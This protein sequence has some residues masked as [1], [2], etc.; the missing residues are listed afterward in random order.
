MKGRMLCLC[1]VTA[2]FALG[3]NAQTISYRLAADVPFAFMAGPTQLPAG[4]YYIDTLSPAVVRLATTDRSAAAMLIVNGATRVSSER[5]GKLVFH[6][7]GDRYFL[8]NVWAPGAS[9]GIVVR[10]SALERE[11][12]AGVKDPETRVVMVRRQ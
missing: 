9:D 12:I 8:A 2:L 10:P 3:V 11:L 5:Q 6:K 1:V 7:Y 4:Q